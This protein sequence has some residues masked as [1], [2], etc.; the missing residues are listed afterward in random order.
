MNERIKELAQQSL[1][2]TNINGC[3]DKVYLADGHT[4]TLSGYTG[5]VS[6]AFVD[7]FAELLIGDCVQICKTVTAVQVTNATDDYQT[8]REM[9]SLICMEEIKF[10]FGVNE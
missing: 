10:N 8:G 9:G 7:K 2:E 3:V 4:I 5:T 1:R 6:K